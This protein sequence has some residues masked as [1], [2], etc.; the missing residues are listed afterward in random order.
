MALTKEEQKRRA[1]LLA[2]GLKV[3][4]KCGRE[5]PVEQFSKRKRSKDGLQNT[6]KECVSQYQQEN[7]EKIQQQKQQYYQ[8][9][10]E[11]RLQYMQ[12]YRQ[13]NKEEI[14][15]QRK[16]YYQKHKEEKRQYNKQ[17]Y[18]ENKEE[19]L[20][21]AKQYGKQYYQENKEK[22]AQYNKKWQKEHKEE[23]AEHMKKYKQTPQ[24][25][26][27]YFNVYGKRRK[28]E[29]AQGNGIT[30][31]QWLEM[32]HFFDWKCAYSGVLVNTKNNRS[33]DHITP[34]AKGGEHEI[35]NCVP[36]DKSLNISKQDKDIMEWYTA[37]DFYSKERL[38]KIL[39]W[40]EYAYNKYG[41]QVEAQ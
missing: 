3:C 39:A 18:Q 32:M 9:T 26:I 12:Q 33:I 38:D 10:K 14:A 31:D 1:E 6:C 7:K 19:I 28:R 30:K 27:A 17:Y 5:L 25:Q 13:E 41:K 21:Y 4:N 16:Q 23:H 37:Q 34:L 22:I 8:E 15:E 40:Q 29:E 35:W 11:E 24:G 36:M 20:Q 2:K